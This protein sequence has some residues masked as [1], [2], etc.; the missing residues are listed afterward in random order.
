MLI[1]CSDR[2]IPNRSGQD[3]QASY[4]LLHDDGS[5]ATPSRSHKKIFNN[6]LHIQKSK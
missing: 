2:F 1:W 6:E 5:P 3:L 4:S